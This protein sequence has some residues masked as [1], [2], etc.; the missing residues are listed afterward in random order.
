MPGTNASFSLGIALNGSVCGPRSVMKS[1]FCWPWP[2]QPCLKTM[3]YIPEKWLR[4]ELTNFVPISDIALDRDCSMY[5]NCKARDESRSAIFD[6]LKRL[7]LV[8][9]RFP[10]LD[11]PCSSGWWFGTFFI[12]LYIWNVI[13]PI[14][15]PIFQRI[16]NRQS[17]ICI[18]SFSGQLSKSDQ[19]G[20]TWIH[21]SELSTDSGWTSTSQ[22]PGVDSFVWKPNG[23]DNIYIHL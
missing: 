22:T 23:V 19:V 5:R 20:P 16:W 15:F 9:T 21:S 11:V 2:Y 8:G 17:V 4:L 14:D 1:L 3:P 6:P 12:F 10:C 7:G 13:I 18:H